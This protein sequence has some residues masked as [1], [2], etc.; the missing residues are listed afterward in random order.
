MDPDSTTLPGRRTMSDDP[1]GQIHTAS[2]M[3]GSQT[4]DYRQDRS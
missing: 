3:V 2:D 1:G 4:D